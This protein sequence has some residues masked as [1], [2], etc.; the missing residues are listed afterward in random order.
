MRLLPAQL[1]CGASDLSS[2]AMPSFVI[3]VQI[4][5]SQKS[6]DSLSPSMHQSQDMK[7]T[8]SLL[9][10][11]TPPVV[12][13]RRRLTRAASVPTIYLRYTY[14]PSYLPRS[15]VTSSPMEGE[16]TTSTLREYTGHSR[17]RVARLLP[18]CQMHM[19]NF[20]SAQNPSLSSAS[21]AAGRGMGSLGERKR[22]GAES[23]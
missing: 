19:S 20:G 8:H 18:S 10:P 23:A 17:Q 4:A 2:L 14:L 1:A 16:M 3:L 15:D 6:T 11:H 13:E 5:F 9:P 22:G 12:S 7:A 21:L